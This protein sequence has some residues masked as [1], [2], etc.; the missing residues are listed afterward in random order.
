[1][2]TGENEW[3]SDIQLQTKRLT[4]LTKDLVYLSRME[5][6]QKQRPRLEFSLSD[7]AEE[8]A[9]S[10]QGPARV[11]NKDFRFRIEPMLSYTGDENALRHAFAM[12]CSGSMPCARSCVNECSRKIE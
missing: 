12:A 3:L 10:F 8:T 6:D 5:E 9:Q 7:L 2:E 1:M 11:Q 4:A